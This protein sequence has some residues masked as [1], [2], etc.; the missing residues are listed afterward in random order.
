M[1]DINEAIQ[2][3]LHDYARG[4]AVQFDIS[5]D[6]LSIIWSVCGQSCPPYRM[7]F[8]RRPNWAEDIC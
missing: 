1:K 2:T 6:R 7:S 4:R 8:E 3:I 5:E